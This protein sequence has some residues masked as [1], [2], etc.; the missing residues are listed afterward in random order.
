MPDRSANGTEQ[1]LMY[2]AKNSDKENGSSGRVQA[3]V[4]DREKTITG[5]GEKRPR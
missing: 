4:S 2:S 1:P 5:R 3:A